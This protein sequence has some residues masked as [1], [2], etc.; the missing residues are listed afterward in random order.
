MSEDVQPELGGFNDLLGFSIT[1]ADGDHVAGRVE[2]NPSHHQPYGLVHGGVYCSVV[3]TAASVGAGLWF[4][5]RG[6]VVGVSNHTNFLRA[7]RAGTLAVRAT[8]VQRGR[9]QQLWSVEITDERERLVAKGEVRIANL[10]TATVVGE[11][12]PQA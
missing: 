6:N 12:G 11:P 10:A 7:T 4:G 1:S 9:T 2:V 3:E 5:E 8:P